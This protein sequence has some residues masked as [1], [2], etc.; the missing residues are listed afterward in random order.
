MRAIVTPST[1][2]LICSGNT[3]GGQFLKWT[4][5]GKNIPAAVARTYRRFNVSTA[6]EEVSVVFNNPGVFDYG[7]FTCHCYS[8]AGD[9]SKSAERKHLRSRQQIMRQNKC[10][11]SCSEPVSV[12]AL[13]SGIQHA[14][15]LHATRISQGRHSSLY[16]KLISYECHYACISFNLSCVL[17]IKYIDLHHRY[18]SL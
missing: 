15:Y 9:S 14:I 12:S 17:A 11:Y 8:M 13:P 10:S 3:S 1:I 5:R 2:L 6:T 16:N 18:H 4:E 7:I